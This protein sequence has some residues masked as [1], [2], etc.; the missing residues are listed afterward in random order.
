MNYK[1]Y[2]PAVG[3]NNK[4][5]QRYVLIKLMGSQLTLK[6]NILFALN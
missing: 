1:K 2:C 5:N 4:S 6:S 3:M